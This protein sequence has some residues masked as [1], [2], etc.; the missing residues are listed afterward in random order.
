MDVRGWDGLY[1]RFVKFGWDEMG[2]RGIA[3]RGVA[4]HT[5]R[6]GT[7]WDWAGGWAVTGAVIKEIRDAAEGS[8]GS[9]AVRGG[10]GRGTVGTPTS[11][12]GGLG[13]W[14]WHGHGTDR[15]RSSVVSS[16]LLTIM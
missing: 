5:A 12:W 2:W 3:W 10:R 8:V 9:C 7:D 15:F 13:L 16:P 14:W 4:W 11:K 6:D 1:Q